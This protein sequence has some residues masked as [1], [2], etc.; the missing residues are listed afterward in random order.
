[1]TFDTPQD[2]KIN[3]LAALYFLDGHYLLRYGEDGK[4]ISKFVRATDVRAAFNGRDIDSGWIPAGVVRWGENA[5]GPWF[6][7]TPPA[8]LV[9]IWL[10]ETL[11]NIPVP[12]TVFFVNGDSAHMFALASSHFGATEPCYRAPFP[13]IRYDDGR[14]CWG[15]NKRPAADP[16]QARAGWNLF[17]EAPFNQDHAGEKCKSY[18]RDVRELL[19]YLGEM[20]EKKFPIKELVQDRETIGQKIETLLREE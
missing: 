1:M 5:R 19:S 9:N 6:V 13:N 4:Q 20:K 12:R 15:S 10:G 14:I 18:P 11:L 3:F 17:F 16:N 8:Q 7:S 2:P